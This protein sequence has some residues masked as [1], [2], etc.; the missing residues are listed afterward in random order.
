MFPKENKAIIEG[1]LLVA[2]EPLSAAKLAEILE[3]S[4][5]DI[6]EL[7]ALLTEHYNEEGHGFQLI[8]LAGGYQI[9]TRA[10]H[11]VYIEQLYQPAP[12]GLSK[13]S[14]E[15]LAIIAYKQPV[16]KSEIEMIRGV[17]VERS[18]STLLEKGLII[19]TGRKEGPGKPIIYGT[20]NDFLRHFGLASLADLPDLNKFLEQSQNKEDADIEKME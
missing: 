4:E 2:N 11:A 17:K 8:Q 12:T 18:L 13:A 6:L 10:E 5:E 9:T 16:T 14:L 20:T 19:E 7:L 3:L 1:L 15:T